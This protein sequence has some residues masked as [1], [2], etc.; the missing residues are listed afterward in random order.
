MASDNEDP[1]DTADLENQWYNRQITK[2]NLAE[3]YIHNYDHNLNHIYNETCH[4]KE[5][6]ELNTVE[7]WKDFIVGVE[8]FYT[9]IRTYFNNPAGFK[10][11]QGYIHNLEYGNGPY[12]M[13][14]L[15]IQ[16]VLLDETVVGFIKSR[17]QLIDEIC[18]FTGNKTATMKDVYEYFNSK[19]T[20]TS[21]ETCYEPEELV[22]KDALRIVFVT[23]MGFRRQ[24]LL[25]MLALS[26]EIKK[27]KSE[28]FQFLNSI[29]FE[30]ILA[31]I[32]M[33][34]DNDASGG[35]LRGYIPFTNFLANE[36]ILYKEDKEAYK[37]KPFETVQYLLKT[38]PEV[39]S[40]HFTNLGNVYTGKRATLSQALASKT[41]DKRPERFTESPPSFAKRKLHSSF[42]RASKTRRIERPSFRDRSNI[43]Y[44][45]VHTPS[46]GCDRYMPRISET[47]LIPVNENRFKSRPVGPRDDT[48][49]G[50]LSR[51]TSPR[52]N[53][54]LAPPTPVSSIANLDNIRWPER[55]PDTKKPETVVTSSIY[56]KSND[57]NETPHLPIAPMDRR[58]SVDVK[59]L[60]YKEI[61]HKYTRT[62]DGATIGSNLLGSSCGKKNK[63]VIKS[64]REQ[65]EE[66][67]K[68]IGILEEHKSTRSESTQKE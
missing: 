5:I 55:D 31:Y 63:E 37:M 9:N 1:I 51:P 12:A 61:I 11:T 29:P 28:C 68:V 34:Q 52:E 50:S 24:T 60:S 22:M 41:H 54:P 46:A 4:M 67:I 40:Q 45:R 15:K 49:I 8:E 20:L 33:K 53:S 14:D 3:I 44:S 32:S 43:P 13:D 16:L 18:A 2:I 38:D 66:D 26:D 59:P 36:Y 30:F 39:D 65:P 42:E 19:R 57:E 62:S 23:A 27:K 58:P 6:E 21:A 17:S 56:P 35:V 7:F 64:D 10:I 48:P 25:W 47:N